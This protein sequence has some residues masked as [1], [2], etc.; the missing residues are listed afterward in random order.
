VR[1]WSATL[2]FERL[3]GSLAFMLMPLTREARFDITGTETLLAQERTAKASKLLV[4][5]PQARLARLRWSANF[6]IASNEE[7]SIV[8]IPYLVTK[9]AEILIVHPDRFVPQ[10][11]LV[12]MVPAEIASAHD[13]GLQ[14]LLVAQDYPLRAIVMS[15]LDVTQKNGAMTDWSQVPDGIGWLVGDTRAEAAQVAHRGRGAEPQLERR[16]RS[17][18]A[19][20]IT[21]QID[22]VTIRP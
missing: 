22:R 19:H 18:A 6:F 9:E 10:E 3:K 2:L 15:A 13:L 16:E 17:T 20:Q 5:G 12:E 14:R 8:G 4:S 1:A 21:G 11:R 7:R